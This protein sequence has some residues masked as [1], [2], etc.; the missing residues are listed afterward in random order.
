MVF[1]FQGLFS[2][3]PKNRASR[4]FAIVVSMVCGMALV[5]GTSTI[6]QSKTL[7]LEEISQKLEELEA[8]QKKM[9]AQLEARHKKIVADRE[10]RRK[11]LAEVEAKAKEEGTLGKR[12]LYEGT[13]PGFIYFP[14]TKTQFRFGGF[15]RMDAVHNFNNMSDDDINGFYNRDIMTNDQ[16]GHKAGG[17]TFFDPS[18]TRL[19]FD[20][21]TDTSNFSKTFK[22]LQVFVEGDFWPNASA[23]RIRHAYGEWGPLLVG[24]TWANW[25]DVHALPFIFDFGGPASGT[26]FRTPMVKWRQPLGDG[27]FLTASFEDPNSE[28]TATDGTTFSTADS[29]D[30]WPDF[31]LIGTVEGKDWHVRL[32]SIFRDLKTRSGGGFSEESALGWGLNFSGMV[33]TIGKDKFGFAVTGGKG[34]GRQLNATQTTNADA[35]LTTSNLHTIPMAGGQAN[36][37]HYWTDTWRSSVMYSY[38]WNNNRKDQPNDAIHRVNYLLTNLVWNPYPLV[39]VGVEYLYGTRKN[40]DGAYGQAHRITFGFMYLFHKNPSLKNWWFGGGGN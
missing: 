4:M 24:Q 40:N 29:E 19:N 39:H 10:A 17:N 32:S 23:F 7:T 13:I 36:Y 38:V 18:T 12:L 34:V 20:M 11:R 9:E 15:A 21:R 30:R 3:R 22:K 14:G 35:V 25:Q 28:I 16:P 33:P 31:L 5:V 1:N 37:Q 2:Q 27:F 6:A 26:G 8:Y